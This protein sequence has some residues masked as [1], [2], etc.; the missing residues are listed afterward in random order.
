MRHVLIEL[1]H[2]GELRVPGLRQLLHTAP[3]M[4]D[5]SLPTIE[6]VVRHCSELNEDTGCTPT[7]SAS[8]AGWTWAGSRPPTRAAFLRTLSSPALPPP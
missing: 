7:A 1:R 2:F 4:H 3:Y 6:A 8:C 5:G